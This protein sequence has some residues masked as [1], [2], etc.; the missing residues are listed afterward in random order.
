MRRP[1]LLVSLFVSTAAYALPPGADPSLKSGANHHVGD[2]SFVKLFGRAPTAADTEQL[3]MTAHL[4]H[5][6]D[7]L[8]SRPATRPGLAAR[9]AELLAALRTYIAKGTTPRNT[10][11][12]WRTP[13]F[14]DQEGTICAVGYLIE[15][16]VGRALPEKIATHHRYDFLEDIAASMPEVR[17][18]V[19]ESG[20]TLEELAS[21]QPAYEE[22]SVDGWRGWELAKFR[23]ADGPSSRYGSGN[24]KD[25]NM[26]GDWKVLD[27]ERVVGKGAMKSGR[28]AWT[29]FYATGEKLA[30]GRYVANAP[31]GRWKMFHR[32]GNLAAEGVFD[33][34]TRVGKWRFYYDTPAKAAM[35]VG[36]FGGDGSVIGRWQHYDAEGKLLARTWT[37]TPAQWEDNGYSTNGGEGSV[38]EVM[39]GSDGVRHVVH[40][41]TPGRD[42]EYNEF[43]LELFSKGKEKLYIS[44]TLGAEAWYGADGVNLVH[45]ENGW[46][47][48]D[49]RWSTTRKMIA[50]QG[51]VP[52]L[53]GVL[54][55]DAVQRARA[56]KLEEWDQMKDTGVVCKGVT[57]EISAARA[58]RLDALLASRD[59]VRSVTPKMVRELIYE[60]DSP[61][62][63]I[64][65]AA[66]DPDDIAQNKREQLRKSDLARIL[67]GSMV[68]YI[69]WPHIDRRF[70]QV[71][72][73]MAG[74]YMKHWA[75]RSDDDGNPS[76]A[77]AE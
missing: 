7:W 15:S 28:G 16:S 47:G 52:R 1:I 54:S 20:L 8:A 42:V 27:G 11:L 41:G 21:I 29:S 67:A 50:Q 46:S 74:R 6:H 22:P 10:D 71:Y 64:D 76:I 70:T 31:E 24:F 36:R 56:A 34:G 57:V 14:I 48:K 44:S 13:V 4:Q 49:C 3:R 77:E 9:R 69:E 40:Q 19:E 30:E 39:P 53:D 58:K 73:T 12:P 26:A 68:M 18:W 65:E 38:L 5:V 61:P 51:D 32:S 25:R 43:K 55:K 63:A 23:P 2:E 59:A 75:S 37:E 62:E 33:G 60:E 72:E 17:Q 45:G 66:D 35:A